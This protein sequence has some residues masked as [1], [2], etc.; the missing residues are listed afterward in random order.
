MI[1]LANAGI[2]KDGVYPDTSILMLTKTN[3]EILSKPNVTQ[4]NSTQLKQ[5][6]S[7]FV[8]LDIVLTW[9]P[10]HHPPPTINFSVTS[11]AA[12]RLKFG[13]DNHQ[14]NLIKIT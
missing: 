11:R 5:L 2:I 12:R 14:S 10:P 6:K 4:L 9:N 3:E 7:N 8:G 13:T 1:F